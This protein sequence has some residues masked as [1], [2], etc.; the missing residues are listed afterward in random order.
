MDTTSLSPRQDV[1]DMW[2]V[3]RYPNDYP[4]KYVARKWVGND[5]LEDGLLIT[6]T[7][8]EIRDQ[9]VEAGRIRLNRSPTDPAVIVEVWI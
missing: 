9:M 8:D 1:F 7:L 5:P 4:N 6:D 3:Y 2:V